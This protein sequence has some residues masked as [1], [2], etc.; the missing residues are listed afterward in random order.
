[1]RLPD[2]KGNFPVA[3]TTYTK[4]IRPTHVYGNARFDGKPA[5]KMEEIAYS[6]YYPTVKEK[7][8]SRG[9]PWVLRY[10]KR[11]S[12]VPSVLTQHDPDH[13]MHL[14]Q[15]GQR[16]PVSRSGVRN[17]KNSAYHIYRLGQ[18]YW[19]LCT[20]NLSQRLSQS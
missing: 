3:V 19:L 20:P 13:S 2:Y 1:M 8:H 6:V 14:L 9:I 7:A 15:D 18:S 5:L 4:P 12:N 11:M 10:V 17:H 16:L